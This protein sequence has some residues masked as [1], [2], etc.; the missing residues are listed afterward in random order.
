MKATTNP[1]I[2]D[3][4]V[5]IEE[6]RPGEAAGLAETSLVLGFLVVIGAVSVEEAEGDD[7]ELDPGSD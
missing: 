4:G 3:I 1:I 6:D 5:L 7:E 2:V